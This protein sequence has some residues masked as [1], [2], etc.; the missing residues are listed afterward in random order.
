[1]KRMKAFDECSQS[2]VDM[3]HHGQILKIIV[4]NEVTS[5]ST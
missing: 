2:R 1:L 4:Q 5:E 3:R